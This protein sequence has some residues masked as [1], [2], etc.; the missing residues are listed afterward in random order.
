[1]RITVYGAGSIGGWMAVGLASAGHDVSVIARGETLHAIRA[2]GL[3]LSDQNGTHM[4][5]VT[6]A[7]R[8]RDLGV[9]DLVI[10]A[11]K[12]PAMPSVAEGIGPLLSEHTMILSAMN[13]V[14]WWFCA[15][16]EGPL[17]DRRLSSV[18][19]HG[20]LWSAIAPAQTLGCV[21][22]ASASMRA[23]GHVYLHGGKRLVIGEASGKASGRAAAL[24]DAFANAG[25]DAQASPRIQRDVWYKLWGN[26]TMNPMSAITG[27]TTDRLISDPLARAFATRIMLEA[28]EIAT[29]MEIGIEQH[30]DE[31]HAS[32]LK[33][34]AMRT[35]MLQDVETNRAVELDALMGAVRELGQLTGVQTPYTDALFGLAR[36]HAANRGLYPR[37]S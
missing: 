37:S 7:E 20:A 34:G 10:V 12:G 24:V 16:L 30:P 2:Q 23:P 26:M 15:G 32:T 6:A 17:K 33:L 29:R 1:M 27:A 11:V 36:V 21:V 18:D 13:G 14:P 22:Y 19:S 5:N 3:L 35:S 31:R 9:Q 4:A 25:F 8:A 28:K